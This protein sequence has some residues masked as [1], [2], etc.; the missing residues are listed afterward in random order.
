MTSS[1]P[2]SWP[3]AAG[4]QPR[5]IAIFTKVPPVTGESA[6]WKVFHFRAHSPV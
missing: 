3:E 4:R 5:S 2:S 1:Q 6:P